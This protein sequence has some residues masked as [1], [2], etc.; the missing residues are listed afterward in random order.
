MIFQLLAKVDSVKK[1]FKAAKQEFSPAKF[2]NAEWV[3]IAS[4]VCFILI[5]A[6]LL[7]DIISLKLI[8]ENALRLLF[9]LGGAIGAW[10]FSYFLGRSKKYIRTKIDEKTK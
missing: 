9:T 7:P 3:Y 2:L 10:C 1:D 5:L 6:V 8:P 4:S